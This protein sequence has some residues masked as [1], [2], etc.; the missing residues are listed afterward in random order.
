MNDVLKLIENLSRDKYVVWAVSTRTFFV[1]KRFWNVTNPDAEEDESTDRTKS[2]QAF[3][4]IIRA[5]G[6]D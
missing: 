2:E 5:L 1:R 4:F 3:A 6:E